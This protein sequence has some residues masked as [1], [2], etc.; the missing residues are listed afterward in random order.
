MNKWMM[1]AALIFLGALVG[2]WLYGYLQKN[3]AAMPSVFRES[4]EDEALAK[5]S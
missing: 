4:T 3:Q 2:V 5:A 1:W